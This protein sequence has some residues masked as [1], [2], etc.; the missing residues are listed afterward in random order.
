MHPQQTAASHRARELYPDGAARLV[1]AIRAR[2]FYS[3]RK[4]LIR[5]VNTEPAPNTAQQEPEAADWRLENALRTECTKIANR[6]A[7][8]TGQHPQ[9]VNTALRRAG[10]PPRAEC[11]LEEL[12]RLRDFLTEWEATL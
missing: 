8:R 2:R 7:Y 4:F 11:D 12:Q 5:L 9:E 6:I 1:P 3:A 10:F